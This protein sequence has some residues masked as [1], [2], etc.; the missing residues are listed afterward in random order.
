M[1]MATT[2]NVGPIREVQHQAG[3]QRGWA[4]RMDWAMPGLSDRIVG[5]AESCSGLGIG[6]A[7]ER[8]LVLRIE[9]AAGLVNPVGFDPDH[10][11]RPAL[12]GRA[13]QGREPGACGSRRGGN[14]RG[15]RPRVPEALERPEDGS[16]GPVGEPVVR[17]RAGCVPS[18]QAGARGVRGGGAE[19]IGE[20]LDEC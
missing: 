15:V 1:I 19:P 6:Y 17:R 20:R 3:Q 16:G 9:T 10:G 7:L 18:D 13:L 14:S 8:V 2:M 4:E 5:F 11:R 12:A